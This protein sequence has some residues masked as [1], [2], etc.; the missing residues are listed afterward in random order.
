MPQIVW[1][2][3]PDG[4][5]DYYNQR[6]YDFTGSVKGQG[7]DESWMPILH[8][9]DVQPCLDAWYESVRSGRDYEIQ[10]RFRDYHT[11]N[12]RWHLGRALPIRDDDGQILR[13]FGTCTDIHDQKQAAAEIQ[14]LNETLEQRVVDRTAQLEAANR[15][16][17]SFSYSVSHDLRAPF[18][19]IDGFVELLRKRLG[20]QQLDETS[21]RYL[22]TIGRT[23]KQAGILIDEL[24][25]FSRMGRSEMR[26]ITLDMDLLIREAQRDLLA[27]IAD[28]QGAL[29]RCP[30]APHP[31]RSL[32]AAAG[33]AKSVG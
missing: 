12:Y 30:P 18:R 21:Q 6:W 4:Y 29:E 33:A 23:A 13:W 15:E 3:R 25:S 27:E 28:R 10:Y 32:D 2:A 1:T 7:G 16:L 9:D 14:Y 24:L 19:H 17:E 5:L 11:G 22:D 31:G 8:P 20:S 26:H